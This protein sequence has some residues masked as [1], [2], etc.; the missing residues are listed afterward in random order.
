MV[1]SVAWV[2]EL[3]NTQSCLFYLLSILFFLKWDE[4]KSRS[5]FALSLLFFAMAITSKTSTVMLP[6]VLGLCLWWRH[7]RV[8]AADFVRLVPFFAISAIAS[9]WTIWEQKYHSGAQGIRWSE[10]WT[11]RFAIAGYDLWFYLS[12]LACP[13]GLSFF[14]PQWNVRNTSLIIFVPLALA[15]TGLGVLSWK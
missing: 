11:Q 1:Q 14:Y 9:A 7:N 6:V 4:L 13:T 5:S 15:L 8:R 12:K 3:K 2:T 10:S